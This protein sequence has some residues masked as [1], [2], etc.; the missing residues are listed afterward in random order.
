MIVCKPPG[1]PTI[2]GVLYF[3]KQHSPYND[4]NNQAYRLN[5][6]NCFPR[7]VVPSFFLASPDLYTEAFMTARSAGQLPGR[8]GMPRPEGFLQRWFEYLVAFRADVFYM[9]IVETADH[10]PPDSSDRHPDDEWPPYA[11]DDPE[12]DGNH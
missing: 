6:T 9:I 5:Y 12:N 10:R 11:F 7:G 2:S 4:I 3:F 8:G 1:Q